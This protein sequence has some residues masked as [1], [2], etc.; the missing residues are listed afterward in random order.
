M[1]HASVLTST[2]RRCVARERGL[3]EPDMP[4]GSACGIGMRAPPE[5]TVK[6]PLGP[7][8]GA[9]NVTNTPGTGFF[10]A[11]V[12]VTARRIGKCVAVGVDCVAPTPT[13]SF[14]GP[15]ARL[16]GALLI[17]GVVPQMLEPLASAFVSENQTEP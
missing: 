15:S 4:Q 16:V 2:R 1:P 3:Y 11:S 7:R 9:A 6:Y 5:R 17:D 8:L 12:T 13:V 14:L 10:S